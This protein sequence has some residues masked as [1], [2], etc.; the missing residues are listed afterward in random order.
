[1]KD[2]QKKVI[3]WGT[4]GAIAIRAAATIL[5]VSLL[6]I[7]WLLFIGGLLLVYI[8]Y[9]LLV[10]HKEH[11]IQAGN[12][13]FAAIR[14]IVIADAAMGLDNVIAVA[15]AAEG[16]HQYILVIIGLLISVPIIIWGSTLFV[17]LINR[18]PWI[19]YIGAAIL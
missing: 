11:N 13:V 19:I 4:V 9:K 5:V 15:G 17:R 14:T 12:S 8:S 2:K 18:Y 10:D 6:N 16:E 3:I 7:P 1:P